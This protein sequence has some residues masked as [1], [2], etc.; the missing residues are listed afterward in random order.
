[1][2]ID[3]KN[4]KTKTTADRASGQDGVTPAPSVPPDQTRCIFVAIIG[5]PNAGKSTL[6]NSLVGAKVTIVTHKVQTTRNI[7]RGFEGRPLQS[8]SAA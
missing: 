1:M 4:N 7:V 5:A 6:V 8:P 3:R 2:A